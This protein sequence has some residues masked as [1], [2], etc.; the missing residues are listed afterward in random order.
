M[1]GIIEGQIQLKT[2]NRIIATLGTDD[3]FGEMAI[4]DASPRMA[5]AIA[6]TDSMLAVI[7]RQLWFSSWS[8]KPRC[9]LFR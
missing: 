2:T 4:I 3:V 6:T 9:S 8:T 7:D 5:T 1:F